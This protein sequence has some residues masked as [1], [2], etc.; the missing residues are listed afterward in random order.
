MAAAIGGQLCFV[1]GEDI[2]FNNL[3][4]AEI[5]DPQT[6]K[7]KDITSMSNKRWGCAANAVGGQLYVVEG[8]GKNGNILSSAE[9]HDPQTGKWGCAAATAGFQLCVVGR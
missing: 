2:N 4:S 1:G 7:W 6:S 3:L 8:Y 5:Y 9:I